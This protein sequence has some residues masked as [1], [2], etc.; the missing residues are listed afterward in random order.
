VT[1]TFPLRPHQAPKPTYATA[2]SNPTFRDELI[3]Y[4]HQP[5]RFDRRQL[6]PPFDPRLAPSLVLTVARMDR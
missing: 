5:S 1:I 6:V 4:R 3:T 2:V